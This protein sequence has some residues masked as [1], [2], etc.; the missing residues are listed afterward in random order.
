[1][2]GWGVCKAWDS[3][4]GGFQGKGVG[5]VVQKKR[6]GE[7]GTYKTY[8]AGSDVQISVYALAGVPCP[9]FGGWGVGGAGFGGF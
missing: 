2:Y 5:R 3:K 1:M 8:A 6:R 7:G 4:G 9:D